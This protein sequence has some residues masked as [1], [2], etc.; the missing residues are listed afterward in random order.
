MDIKL[1]AIKH[2]Q[3]ASQETECFE[4]KL[5]IDGK[6]AAIVSNDGRGGSNMFHWL[7]RSLRDPFFAYCKSLPPVPCDF[8]HGS[9]TE[10]PMDG[11]FFVSELL[12]KCLEEKQIKGWCRTKIVV[13]LKGAPEGE[14]ATYKT[15]YTPEKAARIRADNED[16]E[17]ILNERFL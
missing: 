5:Y 9:P 7:D 13:K 17:E 12:G 10:L 8:G 15:K 2:S 1:K 4:A 16:I 6:C 14:Y 3:F 11:D